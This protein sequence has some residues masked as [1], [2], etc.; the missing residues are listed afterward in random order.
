[1][2]R[3][4]RSSEGAL[5][6]STSSLPTVRR[7][8]PLRRARRPSG[9]RAGRRGGHDSGG[10]CSRTYASGCAANRVRR[11]R[12]C[13]ARR[14]RC[15][16]SPV[17][18]QAHAPG[19]DQLVGTPPRRDARSRHIRVEAHAPFHA[20]LGSV[21]RGSHRGVDAK[22]RGPR[23]LRSECAA[24]PAR[25][26]TSYVGK[27]EITRADHESCVRARRAI[28]RRPVLRHMAEADAASSSLP[29]T[30][31][32]TCRRGS[33]SSPLP[34]RRAR[35]PHQH[36]RAAGAEALDGLDPV[37]PAAICCPTCPGR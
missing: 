20:Q 19:E 7:A 1:M 23:G 22:A 14:R 17:A 13:R 2:R 27:E 29:R 31:S 8:A 18:V 4:R 35:P 34:L 28:R 10:P 33:R 26:V 36:L 30:A 24:R 12:R 25:R 32:T 21:R 9:V 3:G 6:R 5:G 15:L 16:S 11:L 37:E